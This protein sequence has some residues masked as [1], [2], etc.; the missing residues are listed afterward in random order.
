MLGCQS[1]VRQTETVDKFLTGAYLI[2]VSMSNPHV[3]TSLIWLTKY[4][5]MILQQE[6]LKSL[7]IY[8]HTRKG[9][10]FSKQT[11]GLFY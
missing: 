10:K 11:L 8:C 4:S 9:N 1:L 2:Y 5:K 6:S 7:L 3:L